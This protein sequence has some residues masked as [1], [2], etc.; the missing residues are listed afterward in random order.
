MIASEVYSISYPMLIYIERVTSIKGNP[1]HNENKDD[2]LLI[3]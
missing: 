3:N 1:I 2:F